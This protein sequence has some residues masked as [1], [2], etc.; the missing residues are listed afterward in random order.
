[1]KTF[2]VSLIFCLCFSA[3]SQGQTATSMDVAQIR[4]QISRIW[5]ANKIEPFDEERNIRLTKT[6]P[7]RATQ[8]WVQYEERKKAIMLKIRAEMLNLAQS[9]ARSRSA[10]T[11]PYELGLLM[12]ISVIDDP[13][14][15]RAE[16]VVKLIRNL[17]NVGNQPYRRVTGE[18]ELFGWTHAEFFDQDP[19]LA[20]IPIQEFDEV[21]NYQSAN[22]PAYLSVMRQML[23]DYE[24]LE[25]GSTD[26]EENKVYGGYY[27]DNIFRHITENIAAN[28]FQKTVRPW[29][30]ATIPTVKTHSVKG[31]MLHHAGHYGLA[32]REL[33]MALTEH[34]QKGW[35][36]DELESYLF[37]ARSEALLLQNPAL[38]NG[39]PGKVFPVGWQL[40]QN[41]NSRSFVVADFNEDGLLD[42]AI[43]LMGKDA[44]S[45]PAIFVYLNQTDKKYRVQKIT[46]K[47]FNRKDKI[48]RLVSQGQ[49]EGEYKPINGLG[50]YLSCPE[51]ICE[52]LELVQLK[53]D[54]AQQKMVKLE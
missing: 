37:V 54:Q 8:E 34:Q 14:Y 17:G 33:S 40:P 1:M 12:D 29:L 3:V 2:S 11:I 13:L 28:D 52:Q 25:H 43:L 6:N 48:D 46:T 22:I 35:G 26:K 18:S 5:K 27:G 19:R 53:W 50:A 47:E 21:Q 30:L 32:T 36:T 39:L 7:D 9:I 10:E 24:T 15:G 16:K 41:K 42:E 20:S 31:K 49:S 45:G 51:E 4:Q 44:K 38:R 23:R